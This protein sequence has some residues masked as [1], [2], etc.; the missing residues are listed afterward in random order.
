MGNRFTLIQG[1]HLQDGS[2][3]AISNT[4]LSGNKGIGALYNNVSNPT[5][6]QLLYLE[7][8]L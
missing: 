2:N 1:F 8:G 6:G 7:M 3:A 4:L 5:I